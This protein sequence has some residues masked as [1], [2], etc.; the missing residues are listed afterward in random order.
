MQADSGAAGAVLQAMGE[1]VAD[2]VPLSGALP[3][4]VRRL[5]HLSSVGARLRPGDL[6]DPRAA[7]RART[8]PRSSGVRRS[9]RA[10]A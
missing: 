7:A 1:I 5:A 2:A 6:G 3:P 9:P 4:R 8:A 10:T